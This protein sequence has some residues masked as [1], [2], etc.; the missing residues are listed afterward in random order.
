[1]EDG[2]EDHLVAKGHTN[3]NNTSDANDYTSTSPHAAY[4]AKRMDR[5]I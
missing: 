4:D 2:A 1:M 3:V 5:M